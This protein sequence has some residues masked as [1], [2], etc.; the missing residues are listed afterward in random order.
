MIKLT[1]NTYLECG[2]E[3][4]EGLKQIIDNL[5]NDTLPV[6]Q[7]AYINHVIDGHKIW[8]E[9]IKTTT[10]K[11]LAMSAIGGGGQPLILSLTALWTYV[12]QLVKCFID[13]MFII[14]KKE[15]TFNL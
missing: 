7:R 10:A 9:T 5:D 12:M 1:K 3:L 6:K 14:H 11:T 4:F 8:F 2:I 13:N 15:L